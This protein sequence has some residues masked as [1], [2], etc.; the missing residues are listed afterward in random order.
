MFLVV[1]VPACRVVC[2][3]LTVFVRACIL[4]ETETLML[5]PNP[6]LPVF[7]CVSMFWPCVSACDCQ[8]V[9]ACDCVWVFGCACTCVSVC[10][11]DCVCV[12]VSDCVCVCVCV[13]VFECV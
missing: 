9:S 13:C 2:S 8:C 3:D 5:N 6:D 7:M 4:P 1:C 11:G 12:C 10:V